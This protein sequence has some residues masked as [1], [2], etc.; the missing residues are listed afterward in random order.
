MIYYLGKVKKE[1]L[2]FFF[3]QKKMSYRDVE[4]HVYF[5]GVV[6]RRWPVHG[7]AF[8]HELGTDGDCVRKF[9]SV[10]FARVIDEWLCPTL[11][12]RPEDVEA[13]G[14]ELQFVDEAEKRL[15]GVSVDQTGD[16]VFHPADPARFDVGARAVKDIAWNATSVPFGSASSTASSV[17]TRAG[18]D[19]TLRCHLRLTPLDDDTWGASFRRTI[20]ENISWSRSRLGRVADAV[21][22]DNLAS[23]VASVRRVDDPD[24]HALATALIENVRDFLL[25]WPR[26]YAK[27]E[28]RPWKRFVTEVIGRDV[29]VLL[30]FC[31]RWVTLEERRVSSTALDVFVPTPDDIVS[32]ISIEVENALEAL[33]K[34]HFSPGLLSG[35]VD[36]SRFACAPETVLRLRA[37]KETAPSHFYVDE[38]AR[39]EIARFVDARGYDLVQQGTRR[40]P[41]MGVSTRV[42]RWIVDHR[43]II[44]FVARSV[45]ARFDHTIVVA[46]HAYGCQKSGIVATHAIARL[47]KAVQ[48]GR[49]KDASELS[50][51]IERFHAKTQLGFPLIDGH[52]RKKRVLYF[53]DYNSEFTYRADKSVAVPDQTVSL[54][55]TRHMH[56]RLPLGISV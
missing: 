26:S 4:V 11:G 56:E 54:S 39:E 17:P 31:P 45:I 46:G 52:R 28:L 6:R 9:A 37:G 55:Y 47:I 40:Y 50:E 38:N 32:R 2:T 18:D 16:F 3:R 35:V 23:W 24:G 34:P 29:D 20:V 15:C 19:A 21:S 1:S 13:T 33:R 41:I 25:S 10:T 48:E 14:V 49:E 7:P 5:G 30:A 51:T 12:L 42:E 43:V 36:G 53:S 8:R 44:E 27:D 22:R